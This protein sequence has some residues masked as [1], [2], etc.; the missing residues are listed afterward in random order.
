MKLFKKIFLIIILAG[1]VSLGLALGA[2]GQTA[3]SVWI[4][5]R[6]ATYTPADYRGRTLPIDNSNIVAAVDVLDRGRF[7]DLSQQ[8]IYWYVNDSYVNGGTGMTRTVISV[9][10]AADRGGL[11]IRVSLP[12]YAGGIAK[13]MPISVL[14]PQVIIQAPA[15][16]SSNKFTIRGLPFY[17]NVDSKNN[18]NF[19]W[20]VAGNKPSTYNDPELLNITLDSAT[21]GGT[22]IPISLNVTNPNGTF[23]TAEAN[24]SITYQPQ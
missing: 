6:A 5:W 22:N 2:K 1:V 10:G 23:E 18:L 20:D 11:S 9:P 3:P 24:V 21:R 13:T 19:A 17:F 15:T 16:E 4:T 8:T 7:V 14:S 12:D